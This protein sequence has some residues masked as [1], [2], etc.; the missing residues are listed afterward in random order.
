MT[1]FFFYIIHLYTEV[2]HV[3]GAQSRVI[4]ELESAL[5]QLNC[6]CVCVCYVILKGVSFFVKI[7]IMHKLIFSRFKVQFSRVVIY[8][9]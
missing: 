6:V 8:R 4:A 9:L 1:C 2:K 3:T 5:E 7:L